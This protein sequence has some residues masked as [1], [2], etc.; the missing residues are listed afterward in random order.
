MEMKKNGLKNTRYPIHI[1]AFWL[2]CTW[3]THR[4]IHIIQPCPKAGLDPSSIFV[5]GWNGPNERPN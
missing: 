5:E 2:M 3:P 4:G 1:V